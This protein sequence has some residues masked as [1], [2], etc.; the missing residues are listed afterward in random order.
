VKK[1]WKR[2]SHAFPPH[3]TPAGESARFDNKDSEPKSHVKLLSFTEKLKFFKDKL[4]KAFSHFPNVRMRMNAF[5]EEKIAG[6]HLEEY[7]NKLYE[8]WEF[9]AR[10][11]HFQELKPCFAFLVNPFN[12]N[13]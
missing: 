4:P 7:K 11:D 5:R 13:V 9:Q 8:C 3:Y 6:H 12:V 1:V 10:Y 2:R